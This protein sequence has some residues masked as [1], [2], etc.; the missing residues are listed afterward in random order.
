MNKIK[1]ID[2][3]KIITKDNRKICIKKNKNK[4][5][6]DKYNYLKSKDF[7]N[8]IDT[9]IIGDYEVRDY[10]DEIP[11]SYPDKLNELIYLITL[12]HIKTTHYKNM[13]LSK[14]KEI[15][16]NGIDNII[17]VKNYYENLCD[18]YDT[19]LFL[20]PSLFLLIRNIS[21]ILISLDNSRLFL[22][23]WYKIMKD[24]RRKRVVMNHNNLKITN[25]IV[26]DC[27]YLIN[28]DNSSIN[29][30][31]YDLLSLF[32]NNFNEI[33]MTDI[34]DVYRSKYSLYEEEKYYLYFKLLTIEK[35]KLN[36]TELMNT[37]EVRNLLFYL[38][39]VNEFLNNNIENKKSECY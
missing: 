26:S 34:Y 27:N 11:L 30:P 12:L 2:N 22:D 23:K 17:E 15:Y 21:L 32:K 18:R 24:K 29:S 35:L 6:I 14:I 36:N 38:N 33:D 19:Y 7:R 8:F 9:K 16:E 5:I 4:N 1:K 20:K 37:R 39:R 3:L 13:P 10:I 28:W 31:V 25:M